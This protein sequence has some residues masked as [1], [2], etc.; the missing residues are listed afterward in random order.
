[1]EGSALTVATSVHNREATPVRN[2][3]TNISRSTVRCIAA[4]TRKRRPY[5]IISLCR[6]YRFLS[7]MVRILASGWISAHITSASLISLKPC[8]LGPHHYT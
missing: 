6:S 1:M 7:S 8:G 2:R 3:A 4:I 5:C